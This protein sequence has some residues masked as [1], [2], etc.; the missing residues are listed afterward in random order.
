[1]KKGRPEGGPLN[2]PETRNRGLFVG[3]EQ[4]TRNKKQETRNKKQ[5]TRNKKQG[6]RNIKEKE[7][8][9]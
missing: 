6:T 2:K 5:G 7:L 3:Q 9:R 1:M 8:G 4:E